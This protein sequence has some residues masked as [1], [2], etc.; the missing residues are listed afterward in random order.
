MGKKKKKN[1]KFDFN[2]NRGLMNLAGDGGGS[3]EA[4]SRPESV[5]KCAVS[6]LT[7]LGLESNGLV[8]SSL[9]PLTNVLSSLGCLHGAQFSSRRIR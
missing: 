8:F 1:E 6:P 3:K 7:H 9:E 2:F 4:P 5:A